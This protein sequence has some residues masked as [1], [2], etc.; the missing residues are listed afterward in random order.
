MTEFKHVRLD[1]KVY[2][3][4]EI[5]K[6]IKEQNIKFIKLQFVDINGQVKNMSI[7]SE[8]IDK[9]LNNEIMLDGSSIKGFRS[10]ETSDMFFH[11]DINSFQILPWRGNNYCRGLKQYC[12]CRKSHIYNDFGWSENIPKTACRRS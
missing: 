2:T 8:H 11:P 3:K 5:K 9:A 10:I 6:I 4:T 7:P 12:R 1:G